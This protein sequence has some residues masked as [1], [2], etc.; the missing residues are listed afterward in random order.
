MIPLWLALAA[1]TGQPEDTD[2][3][4]GPEITACTLTHT[5]PT[6]LV[7]GTAFTLDVEADDPD[8]VDR[9]TAYWRSGGS[10]TWNPLFLERG[11]GKAWSGALPVAA[12]TYPQ[13]EYY[14]R[15]TDQSAL[16]TTA[17]LPEAG[18]DAPFVVPV[19][20]IG[21]ALPWTEDFEGGSDLYKLGWSEYSA[22]WPGFA[23]TLQDD[24]TNQVGWHRRGLDDFDPIDDWLVTPPLD[25]RTPERIQITWRESGAY[26]DTAKHS[27]WIST[28]S[29]DPSDGSFV[30]L[31][32]V[33]APSEGLWTRS[34][35]VDL[36]AHVG[37]K[38]AW[39]AFRYEGQFS[40][41]WYIDDVI[42]E[43]LGPDLY[44]SDVSW[45]PNPAG[46]GEATTLNVTVTN[47][48]DVPATALPVAW[49]V[50]PALATFG[51]TSPISVAG[52]GT[53]VVTTAVTFAAAAPNNSRVPFSLDLGDRW[54][55]DEDLIVGLPST[56]HVGIH[57]NASGL[58]RAQ[59]GAGDPDAPDVVYDV[60]SEVLSAGT[61]TA[62]IDV[63]DAWAY[64]P[65]TAGPGRWWLSIEATPTVVGGGLSGRVTQFDLDYDGATLASDDLIDFVDGETAIAWLPRP[66][67]P[68]IAKSSTTPS[69]V[70]PGDT[71][72]LSVTLQNQGARTSGA[73]TW[74]LES[75]D[76]DVT[77][78]TTGPYTLAGAEGW[79]EGG[80]STQ[81]FAFKVAA[82][83]IDSTP[84]HLAFV[85]DDPVESF[86]VPLEV[87]VPWPVLRVISVEV[88]GDDDDD[89]R[90]DPAETANLDIRL[91][92][93]GD[94]DSF[95][96]V[97]CTLEADT[98]SE[99]TATIGVAAGSFGIIAKSGAK[100]DDNFEVTVT[101]GALGDTL[102]FNLACKDNS[103]TYTVPVDLDLGEL[104][105]LVLS[106][107]D[108]APD[109]AISG[110]DFDIVNGRYRSDGVTLDIELESS[111]D[112]DIDKVF[113]EL[114]GTSTGAT[115]TYYNYVLQP[116]KD[117][118]SSSL[119]GYERG[120]FT[121]LSAPEV[122]QTSPTKLR[123]SIDLA[124][125]GLALDKVTFGVASGFCGGD[126]YYCDHFQDDWGDPYVKGFD[127]SRW[128]TLEW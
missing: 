36:T 108:D 73:T 121:K 81:T 115:Y 55:F 12:A 37:A 26:V 44:V 45:T 68:A 34:A 57:L 66:P 65:A 27:L 106:T 109:D 117:G 112:F 50:D 71:V 75:T 33:D 61:Y 24:G 90:L 28:A 123:I 11:D 22:G 41:D 14:L 53:A 20:I 42:V 96:S 114:W 46:P 126:P 118:P 127:D 10:A 23:W 3:D 100:A 2:T 49:T 8:G 88:K 80:S 84:V 97:R 4:T 103:T 122:E 113:I 16:R 72:S 70:S 40:D 6:S 79:A 74:H 56:A 52:N 67:S 102:A 30:E 69:T 25:L 43:E 31:T 93:T 116:G 63:T 64:L 91:G 92:N 104:P 51:A 59:L 95:G 99:A 110:Y 119:R 7:Q 87:E 125:F 19:E 98:G 85:V 9:V 38:A 47:R 83:H 54:R 86:T 77:L 60:F 94:R 1:C 35:V 101:S 32:A 18:E 62:D 120:T 124:T 58:L 78:L 111:T 107:T 39:I 5:P 21:A 13:L 76:A 105:W 82:T 17:T 128:L 15:C 29:D 48:T 89:G